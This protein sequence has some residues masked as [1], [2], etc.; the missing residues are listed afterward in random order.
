MPDYP[1]SSG[2]SSGHLPERGDPHSQDFHAHINALV[3]AQE[4]VQ[5]RDQLETA[6]AESPE[7][8]PS[9]AAERF[10]L[11]RTLADVLIRMGDT[12]R[13]GHVLKGLLQDFPEHP[14]VLLLAAER[15]RL[16][17]RN[18]E[19]T[20]LYL[21]SLAHQDDDYVRSR[22]I[23]GLMHEAQY[24]EAEQLLRVGLQQDPANPYLLRRRVRLLSATGRKQEAAA[25]LQ[26][27]SQ[28]EPLTPRDYAEGLKLKLEVLPPDAQ[29]TELSGLLRVEKHRTNPW[30]Q[31]MA[32]E[33]LL[34]LDSLGNGG[35]GAKKEEARAHLLEARRLAG[36]DPFV[37]K[38]LGYLYNRLEDW[39]EVIATL[40][41][42]FIREPRDVPAQQVLL[43]AARKGNKL[44][45]L[46]TIF[47]LAYEK[48]PGFHKLN[49][50]IKKV[51]LLQK[52]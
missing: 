29:W 7:T 8:P 42:A 44:A 15:H 37:L 5:A 1:S 30:L 22:A 18:A 52:E 48:H 20:A 28:T 26:T 43:K 31:V 45:E 11:R 41:Q 13:A 24:A 14:R 47:V 49:G 17:G 27:A 2:S 19:A 50:L 23:D 4:Y 12:H 38:S 39:A 46:H 35:D 32:A 9:T 16:E 21:Q 40:G 34:T 10:W 51:E 6:L 33:L 25:L 3:R 36:S